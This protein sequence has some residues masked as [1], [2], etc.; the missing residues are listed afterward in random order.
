MR[1]GE[2][3]AVLQAYGLHLVGANAGSVSG[4]SV[5]SLVG[6][7]LFSLIG[8]VGGIDGGEEVERENGCVGKLVGGEVVGEVVGERVGDIEGECDGE[9]K[10]DCVG[11]CDGEVEG[12]DEGE[13]EGFLVGF[14]E[15]DVV[16]DHV[17]FG[18]VCVGVCSVGA[19]VLNKDDEELD[20]NGFFSL[21]F[22]VGGE[23][24]IP[25]TLLPLAVRA[26]PLKVTWDGEQ[27]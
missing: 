17:N 15:G 11:E 6:A 10:G 24:M 22:R 27:S 19:I 3:D 16:G 18:N 13:E 2:G 5:L 4:A 14:L 25:E 23:F 12:E 21:G 7:S 26:Y 20:G 8:T 9:C 1:P